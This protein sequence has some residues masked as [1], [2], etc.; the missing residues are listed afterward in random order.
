MPRLPIVALLAIPLLAS[1]GSRP[2]GPPGGGAPAV[3]AVDPLPPN[4]FD[5]PGESGIGSG[6]APRGPGREQIALD[7]GALRITSRPE[8]GRAAACVEGPSPV[9]GRVRVRGRWR[10]EGVETPKPWQ[11]A[12]VLAA[13]YGPD[14][15]FLQ[16]GQKVIG[17]LRGTS[18][19]QEF[20]GT[21][22]RPDGASG[23]RLCVELRDATAGT[24][25]FRDVGV[26]ARAAEPTAPNVLVLLVDALRPDVLGVYGQPLPTS[27][28]IDAFAAS[29]RVFRRAW[30]QYTWT[31]PS[32]ATYMTS[33]YARTHGWDHRM[34]ST[35]LPALDDGAPTLAQ[36][37]S[38]AGWSTAGITASPILKPAWGCARGFD[39]WSIV[40]DARAV[41]LAVD[42][43]SGWGAA[44][45]PAFL[46]VHMMTLHVPVEPSAEAWSA[47]GRSPPDGTARITYL[48]PPGWEEAA[49]RARFPDAYLAAVRDADTAV[50][51]ILDAL[52]TA[53]EADRTLVVLT[54]DHGEQLLEHGELGHAS[55]LWEEVARVPLVIRG[56]G[57]PAG[58][59]G[60]RPGRLIDLAPT[61]VRLAGL[62]VPSAWQ[63]HSLLEPLAGEPVVVERDQRVAFLLGDRKVVQD[64][65]TGALLEAWDLATDPGERSPLHAPLPEAFAPVEAA[66]ASWRTATPE[67]ARTAP[68]VEM[69]EPEAKRTLQNLKVLGYVE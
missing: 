52:D 25:W 12:R 57:V 11:G 69:S 51:R 47:I 4:P 32:F 60:D 26:A 1:C 63:G 62:P 59:E 35:S 67:A 6:W 9:P 5:Q 58:S 39:T 49:W 14:G 13:F 2:P 55:Y 53:G 48:P 3:G 68:V 27:P 19:W 34:G 33:R 16:G 56:P 23:V 44:E 7:D 31:Q 10:T 29:A 64:R 43:V 66:A 21:A 54:A 15:K 36:V 20:R 8:G 24:A 28:R 30:T 41:D 42:E 22:N 65:T 17:S 45:G 50:G 37:L 61:L 38:G 18:S 46:Y 40:N